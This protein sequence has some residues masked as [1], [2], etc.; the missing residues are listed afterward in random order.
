MGGEPIIAGG[1]LGVEAFR[2]SRVKLRASE[3]WLAK[4]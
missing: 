2:T 1:R 4:P 3:G